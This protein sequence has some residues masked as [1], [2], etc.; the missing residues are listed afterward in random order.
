MHIAQEF[1]KPERGSGSQPFFVVLLFSGSTH[2]EQSRIVSSRYHLT[3]NP[4]SGDW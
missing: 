3:G 2:V 1:S 4:F